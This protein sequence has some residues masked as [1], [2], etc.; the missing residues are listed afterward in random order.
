LSSSGDG[1][2]DLILIS[3][4]APNKIFYGDGERPGDYSSTK[5]NEFGSAGDGSVSVSIVQISNGMPPEIIVGN[6]NTQDQLF[7]SIDRSLLPD[8]VKTDDIFS[9][10]Y[11][12]FQIP[13][14]D[15]GKTTDTDIAAGL[16]SSPN[17]NVIVLTNDGSA[18]NRPVQLFEI[19]GALKLSLLSGST[20]LSSNDVKT[21]DSSIPNVRPPNPHA[22]THTFYLVTHIHSES[23]SVFKTVGCLTPVSCVVLPQFFTNVV[24]CVCFFIFFW[25][26]FFRG[27]TPPQRSWT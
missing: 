17:S 13:G 8:N 3:H 6:E 22:H 25:F 14:T 24:L 23:E 21:L 15:A 5:H 16:G 26:V 9:D 10:T 7:L 27:F 18:G 1:I 19:D 11:T 2:P 4:D 20:T 12:E